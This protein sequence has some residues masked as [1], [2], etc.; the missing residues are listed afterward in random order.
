MKRLPRTIRQLGGMKAT[1]LL[2]IT[3][4]YALPCSYGVL[5]KKVFLTIAKFL[6]S[7]Q[8]LFSWSITEASL[9]K[10]SCAL[11][12]F[13]QE[14]QEAIGPRHITYNLHQLIIRLTDY[15]YHLGPPEE[16]WEFP[17]DSHIGT[18]ERYLESTQEQNKELAGKVCLSERQIF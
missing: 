17:F 5:E 13:G 18:L 4:Y 8:Y 3:L 2:A 9:L 6:A 10:V 15:V 11:L 1:V 12:H 16:F 7:S 14:V